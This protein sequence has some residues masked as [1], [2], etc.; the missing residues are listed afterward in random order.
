MGLWGV[1]EP[2][3]RSALCGVAGGAGREAGKKRKEVAK[4]VSTLLK[5]A[6]ASTLA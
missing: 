1:H 2:L 3:S 6:L 5:S 4:S